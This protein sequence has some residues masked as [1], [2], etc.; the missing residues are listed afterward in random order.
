MSVH[1]DVKRFKPQGFCC[2]CS[3]DDPSADFLDA[4]VFP[5]LGKTRRDL[6]KE[7]L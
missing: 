7:I 2:F 4:C 6:L 5:T 3:Q 1:P